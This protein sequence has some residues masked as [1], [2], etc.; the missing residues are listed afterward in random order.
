[1]KRFTPLS[2]LFICMLF[3]CPEIHSQLGLFPGVDK[4][5]GNVNATAIDTANKILYVGG[6]FT[7]A[8]SEGRIGAVVRGDGSI[9]PGMPVPN[10][11]VFAAV[12]DG[13]GGWYL[14]GAFQTVD[15]IRR[16]G[17]VHV[18]A[19]G[20]IN[21]DFDMVNGQIKSLLLSGDT[22]YAGGDFTSAGN[23]Y[24]SAMGLA[25]DASGNL[26]FDFP[27]A[28]ENESISDVAADGYG[29]W[30][31]GGS[32]TKLGGVAKNYIAQIS[33]NGQLGSWN[34]DVNGTVNQ[35]D[36]I[37]N[38]L[39]ISGAF[40]QVNG[41][42]R[43][44]FAILDKNNG[45]LL[46]LV[47]D[48]DGAVD[49]SS[50][51]ITGDTLI[52]AGNFSKIN[53]QSRNG[54][55]MLQISSG[56]LL[57]AIITPN[58]SSVLAMQL[59]NNK[60]YFSG[61]F[62]QVNGI[63]RTGLAAFDLST[64]S[65]L[66]FNPFTTAPTINNMS[67]DNN[68]LYTFGFF[69]SV[70]A[71]ARN[72][73]AAF[74][75]TTETLTSFTPAAIYNVTPT[76]TTGLTRGFV[77]GNALYVFG[78]FNSVNDIAR[79]GVAAIDKSTGI[80]LDYN[81]FSSPITTTTLAASS[82]G[83]LLF[84][85]LAPV[86][87]GGNSSARNL[88]TIN[89]NTGKIHT[90]SVTPNSFVSTIIKKD[91]IIYF[92]GAFTE[93]NGISRSKL[94]SINSATGVLTAWNPGANG[95]VNA[96]T[97]D[98]NSIYAGGV[99]TQAG[100]QARN[101]L[102]SFDET[103]GVVSSWDPNSNNA[104]N[105][106]V[107]KNG[108]LFAGGAFTNI[109][110][111][112]R[113]RIASFNTATGLLNDFNPN[114][115]GVVNVM[116]IRNDTLFTSGVFAGQGN[117]PFYN[118]DINTG[119]ALNFNVVGSSG[120]TTALASNDS[121]IY[122]GGFIGSFGGTPR[123]N[124]AAIDLTTGKLTSFD[125]PLNGTVNDLKIFNN[126]LYVAG[127]FTTA[128]GISRS[129]IA[130]FDLPSGNLSSWVP[131]PSFNGNVSS[132]EISGNTIYLGGLLSGTTIGAN[133]LLPRN[134]LAAFDLTTGN[135]LPL[136][137]VF[138]SGFSVTSVLVD[139]NTL[140][141][142]GAFTS[143]N[144]VT[145]N[146][147]ASFD[148]STGNLT[149]WDP[150]L[151]NQIW[152]M[153]KVGNTIIA[154]GD[155]TTVGNS[156]RSRVAQIDMTTGL[157]SAFDPNA[158][159]S[160][161]GLR[162]FGNTVYVQ[163]SYNIINGQPRRG[164]SAF[165]LSSGKI[166]S[167]N[168]NAADSAALGLSSFGLHFDIFQDTA[169]IGGIYVQSTG[170]DGRIGLGLTYIDKTIKTTLSDIYYQR[171][172]PIIV[173]YDAA[174]IN[175]PG[176]VYTLELSDENGSFSNP[177]L[178]AS[179]PS[180]DVSGTIIGVLPPGLTPG[181]KYRVRINSS[182][183]A[184]TGDDNG[185]D[186]TVTTVHYLYVNDNNLANDVYTT[187]TGNNANNGTATSPFATIS[188][189][190][191]QA[192]AGDT[193]YVDAGI[194]T[195]Q[196]TIDKG[197]SIIGVDAGSSV[198]LKPAVITPPPG[199]FTEPGTIQTTQNIGDV[200]IEK[201]SVTGDDNGVTPIIIQ[202]GGSVKN[203]RLIN[204][205]Q[206]IYFRVD[207]AIK[208][209]VIE[210]NFILASFIAINC[211]GSGLT[212]TLSNNSISL[213]NPFFA[214]GVFAGLD[215]GPIVQ[216]TAINNDISNY[217]YR[218]FL[219]NSRN[220]SITQN[221]ILASASAPPD[222]KAIDQF[223]PSLVVATCNWYGTTNSS[224]IAGKMSG[225]ITFT[226]FL[227]SG[228]DNNAAATGFLPVPGACGDGVNNFYVNDNNRANDVFTTSVGNDANPGTSTAPFATL[229]RAIAVA[230][231]NSLIHIDAGTYAEQVIINKAI[232]INGA[233]QDQATFTKPTGTLIPA[234]GPF[235]E[236]GLFETTQGVG[237]VHIRRLGINSVDGSSQNIIIQGGGSVRYCKLLNGGQGV[238]FR[239]ESGSRTAFV[240]SNF[241][242]PIWIGV[243][244][245]GSGL[246]AFIQN[247]TISK[248]GG[249]AS[250]IFAG[251]DFGPVPQLTI[252]NNTITDYFDQGMFVNAFSSN[253][254]QN[255]ITGTQ[256]SAIISFSGNL[257]NATCNW[258]GV[259]SAA[260]VST[261][262][263]GNINY[264]PW[265]SSGADN[266]T[267]PGFQPISGA[268]NGTTFRVNVDAVT[269]ET[270]FGA[271]NGQINI[272]VTGGVAPFQFTWTKDGDAGFVS[273]DED[274]SNLGQGTYRLSMS[275][276]LGTTTIL[277]LSG[278]PVSI[279][280]TIT[281][282]TLLTASATGSNV[283]CFGGN[284]GS[285]SVIVSGGSEPYTYL[286]SNGDNT[287]SISSLIAGIYT[288]TVTDNHGCI[289][290]S[291]YE[292][293]Q[294]AVLEAIT[295]G[296]NVSCAGGTNGTATVS[297]T[298]G[299][300]PYS[301]LWSNGA[302]TQ[303]ITG[304]AAGTYSVTVTD[305]HNCNTLT[306][307]TVTEPAPLSASA[308]GNHVSCNSGSNGSAQVTVSG[309]TSPYTYLWNTGSAAQEI[310]GLIAGSYSVT[311]TDA[312]GCITTVGFEVTEP[313]L[314]T[315]TANG[316]AVSCFGGSNG[317]VQANVSGGTEPYSY[318]WSNGA[319]TQSVSDLVA[320][321][322]SVTITDANGCTASAA[323][324]VTQ[325]T[326]LSVTMT[327]T[328]AN[329]NG[330][331]T[332]T[333]AGGTAPYSYL[334]NNG[335][336]TQTINS[337]PAGTYTVIVTDANDCNIMGSFTVLGGSPINPTTTFTQPT[338]FGLS[339]GSITVTGA[340][341]TLPFTYNINGSAFQASNVFTGL[342]AGTY[343]VGVKDATGCADFSTRIVTQ[344]P[345][346]VATLDSVRKTCAGAST[347]RIFIT[348][349]GGSGAK[350]YS[351][352][353]PNG[354]T[355]TVQDPNNI[356]AGTYS[357]TVTDARG[358]TTGLTAVV[359]EWPAVVISETV[360]NVN[361]WGDFSGSIDITVT[362]G[363]GS[364]FT[365][366]W[367]GPGFT[368]TTE[369]ISAI[370]SGIYRVTVRDLGST[371]SFQKSITVSQPGTK[372]SVGATTTAVNG[373]ISLGSITATGA[374]GTAP[375]QY[376]LDGGTYQ[377]TALFENAKGGIYTL[378]VKDAN[379]CTATRSVTVA[380][381]GRDTFENN[382][383]K[384]QARLITIGTPINA[385]I[386]I[387]TDTTDWFKFVVPAGGGSYVLSLT[388]PSASFV[389]DLFPTGNNYTVIAP[390][391]ATATTKTYT[392]SGGLTYNIRVTGGLSYDCY[393]LSVNNAAL[394]FAGK[395]MY[396]VTPEIF[397]DKMTAR[398]YPNPHQGS[399][400]IAV[401]APN[402]G[403][404]VVELFN[405]NGQKVIA[406][407]VTLT[408]GAQNTIRFSDVREAVLFYRI[409]SVK[410]TI[411]GKVIGQ[412]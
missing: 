180:D 204:G 269:P 119:A 177:Q 236:I 223:D 307:F 286:W 93:V 175:I 216:F 28:T 396:T 251:I 232:V 254:T 203:C 79:P 190:V 211:Q 65:L 76:L 66:N 373:C 358:C 301:Y 323:F 33:S 309:G 393:E 62:T 328:R 218:G 94:A 363:T 298:G 304:L 209:A 261:K 154:G 2:G 290:T 36:V 116:M 7:N 263:T 164:T 379:G 185:Q 53:G 74:D 38:Y 199:P 288:V 26:L 52:I 237:D 250:A 23:N 227:N 153:Y 412:F 241:I 35:L 158:N 296:T 302:T 126:K 327:G 107:A 205:N 371:C 390:D 368:A 310:A 138:N 370:R 32:F 213:T 194:Y 168:P 380:D 406:K 240:N 114:S 345:L 163:G 311:V 136:A 206:G 256:G 291:Q 244:C 141:A 312:H 267:N 128:D 282:P 235:N 357:V 405:S 315:A 259:T 395:E 31:V 392:L 9:K 189:A 160:V 4:L 75:L 356:P 124:L 167:W 326:V 277:N 161:R 169:I 294:P 58:A 108:T 134:A 329:C 212:A 155:F 44:R 20:S 115:G 170:Y 273:H 293:T 305:A 29:G 99:F 50:F 348:V 173:S 72:R 5:N 292:V 90:P 21:T 318:L 188:Y 239:I 172:E 162:V 1:M 226:P 6:I 8:N 229:T 278:S 103:T 377:S 48:I 369:D 55:A 243:N 224:V 159:N 137:P 176:N 367:T 228:V 410:Q 81:P 299:T 192:N 308:S 397:N 182:L 157:P 165:Y 352:T 117:K 178:L 122:A 270:C 351:W 42:P 15:I 140:Y 181:N 121:L 16:S 193:I 111:G 398:V 249:Y 41:Q 234:P 336:T 45:S 179:K 320:G 353:G 344:P 106:L 246:S 145:R 60:L 198:V 56:L 276:A 378:G 210:N 361:C 88:V 402:D 130:A 306:Q 92:G 215:F 129:R 217:N 321:S 191:S 110:A 71:A 285:A 337:V 197:I 17:L 268:C 333:P 39:L 143:V 248:P 125:H 279:S 96:I 374:G 354:F 80:L 82:N 382:N 253:V 135:V 186:I 187:T 325:P 133:P 68:I 214:A 360:V 260:A 297:V 289:V 64:S 152:N 401:D 280:A 43:S 46:P 322:Y 376:N 73:I 139:N 97:F 262:F 24:H 387:V 271:A 100:G 339:N 149:N 287:S 366:S 184:R 341:G 113:N 383:L 202:S 3:F 201:L 142:G 221:S 330:S 295:S 105:S 283:N 67:L 272:S 89:T 411:S 365:Y 265:L 104:V 37:Q 399:F 385:R 264:S 101:R 146:R 84:G 127:T 384:T 59:Y 195:E 148:L 220:T 86:M 407:K 131:N 200:N 231:V 355:S 403:E 324:T 123:G 342:S 98:G 230:P 183:P 281:G 346:L 91:G 400:I 222:A 11:Q 316:T 266:N 362:G 219:A 317:S 85:R 404:A 394:P 196:V 409:I 147:I 87:L 78:N 389:F 54:I 303:S 109:G 118:F 245:Q 47:A 242:Q 247:N 49:A 156:T 18:R 388:H 332:A 12:S 257:L 77:D 63:A 313:A 95:I 51:I 238:F 334:W 343:V 347:G 30:F 25:T 225:N 338:C 274:P 61:N 166:S 40:T 258:T 150:N 19:D 34:A 10:N 340:T 208:T 372:L 391:N 102:A 120:Q 386:A 335:A 132:I 284:N 381:N 255:S 319:T 22:L 314:L 70:G 375:Y 331:A 174:G 27:L 408:K 275:D 151:N 14:G 350:T 112:A 359:E 69:T 252:T 171:S 207:P 83:K 364:G 300:Q 144:G 349:T 57:P 13:N 233:G